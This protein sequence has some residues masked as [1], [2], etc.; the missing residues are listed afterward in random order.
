MLKNGIVSALIYSF[1]FV[2][3]AVLFV[4]SYCFGWGN[5][6]AYLVVAIVLLALPVG[7]LAILFFFSLMRDLLR[8]MRR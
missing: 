6:I 5:W 7:I 2:V 1:V 8:E 4:V 3:F